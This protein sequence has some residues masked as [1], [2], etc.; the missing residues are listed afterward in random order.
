[1]TQSPER[2]GTAWMRDAFLSVQQELQVK[3]KTAAG[4]IAHSGTQGAVTEAHWIEVLRA[5]LPNRYEVASGI[6]IDSMGARSQQIDIVIFDRHFTPILLGQQ[7]HRYIPAEAVYAVFESKPHFDKNYLK[8]AGDKA[9]SVR[10]L[11]RTSIDIRHAGGVFSARPPF[12]IV[13][14]IVAPRS[15][16]ADG[17]GH[18]FRENLPEGAETHVDCGCALE[19][20]AFDSFS[21]TLQVVPANGALIWFLF[22]LLGQ[23][24]SLGSVPAIDWSAYAGIIR[25]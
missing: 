25:K 13:S 4:S 14:G 1:M 18:S 16:W 23:L 2:T 21:R 22:R 19:H 7:S 10:K 5:Y 3:L 20:G 17:L 6:V 24:Q 8:Y 11:H 15:D 9:A 12:P